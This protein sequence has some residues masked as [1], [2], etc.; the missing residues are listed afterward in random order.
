MSFVD[1]PP[2]ATPPVLRETDVDPNPLVQF[3]AWLQEALAARLKLPEAMTLATATPD[4]PGGPVPR[5]PHW[6]GFR[7]VPTMIE[8][9]QGQENR[10]H[11]RL[12]YRRGDGGRWLLERLAP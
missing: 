7:V 1:P 3:G 8:F 5:P 10:L 11:D 12:R 4:A 6:G 2:S 9:W